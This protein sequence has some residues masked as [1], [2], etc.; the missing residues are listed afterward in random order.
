[1]DKPRCCPARPARRIP[2]LPTYGG[3]RGNRRLELPHGRADSYPRRAAP[4]AGI[5][6]A[7]A[8]AGGLRAM[9]GNELFSTACRDRSRPRSAWDALPCAALPP[10]EAREELAIWCWPDFRYRSAAG[11]SGE[12]MALGRARFTVA[13]GSATAP[14]CP[15]S[16]RELMHEGLLRLRPGT[17]DLG[18]SGFRGF[19]ISGIRVGSRVFFR[20]FGPADADVR[21]HPHDTGSL[22]RL[23]FPDP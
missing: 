13:P 2:R 15:N 4:G 1:M 14:G 19:M 7:R 21:L 3:S 16:N 5:R 8:L 11:A 18:V 17:L 6:P 22:R 12:T 10:R 9:T 23:A 20:G